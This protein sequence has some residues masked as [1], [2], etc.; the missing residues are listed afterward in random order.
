M[1]HTKISSLVAALAAF[2]TLQ[3]A[4]ATLEQGLSFSLAGNAAGTPT[5]FRSVEET[6]DIHVRITTKDVINLLVDTNT[7]AL[8]NARLLVLSQ[9]G[10]G[11]VV[12]NVTTNTTATATNVVTTLTT[13]TEP[14]KVV[15]RGIKGQTN[16]VDVTSYFHFDTL[17]NSP[18]TKTGRVDTNT[19]ADLGSLKFELARVVIQNGTNSPLLSVTGYK[20][21]SAAT[22]TV[23]V[24]HQPVTGLWRS[25]A[26][27]NATG[28]A[29]SALGAVSVYGE[30]TASVVGITQ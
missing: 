13:N 30:V 19:L 25:W 10:P 1:K 23:K 9:F 29:D 28:V 26:L 16:D 11:T 7:A 3:S 8:A 22:E 6:P 12:T 17:T 21:V 18:I 15:V 14:R 27:E 24:N 4:A 20:T 5:T 2:V